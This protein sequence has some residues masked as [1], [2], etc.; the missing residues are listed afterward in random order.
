MTRSN[1]IR[2]YHCKASPAK[3]TRLT[4]GLRLDSGRR[5]RNVRAVTFNHDNAGG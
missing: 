3:P 4:A 5:N 2:P 1:K